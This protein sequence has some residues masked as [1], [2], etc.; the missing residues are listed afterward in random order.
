MV[1]YYLI[2]SIILIPPDPTASQTPLLAIGDA[3]TNE[4]PLARAGLHFW[5]NHARRNE[6]Q[7]TRLRG[8]PVATRSRAAAHLSAGPRPR[9]QAPEPRNM[10]W[11][12][13]APAAERSR[14]LPG[15]REGARVPPSIP[16]PA[17]AEGRRW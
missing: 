10:L 17:A 9:D 13:S 12:G 1:I 3:R 15:A 6:T 8:S 11:S 5:I 16:S 14:G 2:L 4:L 7:R